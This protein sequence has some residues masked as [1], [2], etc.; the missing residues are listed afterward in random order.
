MLSK[1]QRKKLQLAPRV[2]I[3]ALFFVGIASASYFFLRDDTYDSFTACLSQ[4]SATLYGAYW[5]EDCNAQKELFGVAADDLVYVECSTDD[6]QRQ[7]D[8]CIAAGITRYPTWKIGT[9]TEVRG[10]Q[11]LE[12]LAGL[13][14]CR[15]E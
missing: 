5:C 1:K 13:T 6:A 4:V 8:E 9:T 11:T 10:V 15:I 14:G 2:F 7:T 3:L 12:E